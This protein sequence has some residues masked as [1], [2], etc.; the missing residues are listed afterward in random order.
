M[1][2]PE[3]PTGNNGSNNAP[4]D[5]PARVKRPDPAQTGPKRSALPDPPDKLGADSTI[6]ESVAH[7]VRTGY[8]V[9]SE[10]IRLGREAAERFRHGKYNIRDVPNDLN[11]ATM[12]VLILARELSTTTFDVCA[13]LL[14]E[15]G[16]VQ[17]PYDRSTPPPAFRPTSASARP[18][19]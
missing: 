14:K 10:N 12:R 8:E 2:I 18:A 15:A 9:V 6:N 13:R 17:P 3:R 11:T 19:I 1:T 4:N 16:S 5:E 7:A